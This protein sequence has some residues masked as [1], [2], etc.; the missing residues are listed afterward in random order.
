MTPT[1]DDFADCTCGHPASEHVRGTG[2][3]R[4]HEAG[5]Q[6]DCR[7]FEAAKGD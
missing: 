1:P 5:Q 3:C 2:R 4:V 6:C 7:A